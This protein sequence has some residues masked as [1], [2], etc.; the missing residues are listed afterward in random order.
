MSLLGKSWKQYRTKK[1]WC[2]MAFKQRLSAPS[3]TNK[4]WYGSNPFYKAGYGL[5]NCTCYAWGR[6]Y[7]ILG[8]KPA[9]SLSNAENWYGHKDGYSRGKT[10]RL[11]A[12][13][14]WA[15]GK[16]G[17]GSDGAGH[18]AIVEAIYEDGSILISQSGWK[19]SRFWTSK[20]AKGYKK[21]GYTFLGFIYNPAVISS[22]VT[23]APSIKAGHTYTLQ[24]NMKVRTGAGT[25]YRWKKRSELTAD[26][27]KNAQNG[28]YAV[29]KKGTKVTVQKVVG[30]WVKIPSGYVCAKQGGTIYI[31]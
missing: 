6:F 17:N 7:E 26:G 29:L 31:K 12:V 23:K 13:I 16:V 25:K 28:T 19:S 27:K 4:Y 3:T 2:K 22:D 14:C 15:K 10:P 8:K 24:A 9:L 20:V 11:G 1:E 18:V 30:D 5:P 21:S